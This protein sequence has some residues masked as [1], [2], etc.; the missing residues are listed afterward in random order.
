MTGR[1]AALV[2]T[3]AALRSESARLR[4]GLPELDALLR[5]AVPANPQFERERIIVQ[6]RCP[7]E[8]VFLLGYLNEGENEAALLLEL[9]DSTAAAHPD[10]PVA[11]MVDEAW[12]YLRTS[13][14]PQ[15]QLDDSEPSAGAALG[16]LFAVLSRRLDQLREATPRPQTNRPN[17]P[18]SCARCV[19]S[20]GAR[21]DLRGLGGR[22]AR[23]FRV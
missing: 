20:L 1:A 15:W 2:A 4:A 5:A 17:S 14:D 16:Y 7:R 3:L 18:D 6:A 13:I 22:N 11:H 12:Y 9:I 21:H 8:L 10:E 23:T 19:P